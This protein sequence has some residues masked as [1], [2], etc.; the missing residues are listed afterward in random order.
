MATK[1][2]DSWLTSSGEPD[3]LGFNISSNASGPM[4]YLAFGIG[5]IDA[6]P[7][8]SVYDPDACEGNTPVP[9]PDAERDCKLLLTDYWR[10]REK[11]KN[12]ELPDKSEFKRWEHITD[13]NLNGIPLRKNDDIQ[14]DLTAFTLARDNWEAASN[15]YE[16]IMT[17]IKQLGEDG[18]L[19]QLEWD[20]AKLEAS[21][22]GSTMIDLADAVKFA[23]VF[24]I[25]S[26][27]AGLLGGILLVGEFATI[28]N[29]K[30]YIKMVKENVERGTLR[31][32]LSNMLEMQ[33]CKMFGSYA[34]MI[35][36]HRLSASGKHLNTFA[37]LT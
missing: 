2:N 23:A 28:I 26:V 24:P 27:A 18:F 6:E 4:P 17:Q 19:K 11:F 32:F 30:D 37:R 7:S 20:L 16:K 3:D 10:H 29:M 5:D 31:E 34:Q 9:I 15:N 8:F 21:T 22:G 35:M 36:N 13:T 25:L 1:N 33:Y 12:D 14:D